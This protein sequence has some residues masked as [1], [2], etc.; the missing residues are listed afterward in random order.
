[1]KIAICSDSHDNLLNIEKFLLFCENDKIETILHCGDWCA[2]ATL[3]FFREHFPGEIYGVIG[4]VHGG[5]TDMQK[6]A[7]ENNINL[8]KD[9]SII[10]LSEIKI[11]I[12]HFPEK[13]KKMAN[14]NNCQLI[15]Y[16]HNHKPWIEN[17]NDT[18]L[19]N[20]GTLAGMFYKSTFAIIE[21]ETL[22][23]D[24]KILENI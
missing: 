22:K 12:T 15:L 3:R 7:A 4:N 18:Y 11:R 16:G 14:E 20:P 23:A 1:M 5:E 6:K 2:P 8:Q 17:I 9:A 10:K 19:I 24:L 13:A 21:T